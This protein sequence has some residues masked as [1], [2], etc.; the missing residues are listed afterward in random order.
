MVS[1]KMGQKKWIGHRTPGNSLKK[2]VTGVITPTISGLIILL[3]TGRGR[4]LY[5]SSH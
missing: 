5:G 3:V 2:W 1:H 4:T